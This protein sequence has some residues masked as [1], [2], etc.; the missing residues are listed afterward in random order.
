MTRPKEPNTQALQ[1]K[2]YYLTL[3][4]LIKRVSQRSKKWVV[5]TSVEKNKIHP[6]CQS[7]F[8]PVSPYLKYMHSYSKA[9]GPDTHETMGVKTI[10]L[11]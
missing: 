10:A 5:L 6:C 9:N 3:L 2:N 4:V 7:K 8:A 11:A 1:L